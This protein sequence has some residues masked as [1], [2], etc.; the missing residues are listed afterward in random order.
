MMRGFH[1]GNGATGDGKGNVLVCSQGYGRGT[2]AG[3][4]HLNP[5]TCES[6]PLITTQP[7]SSEGRTFNSPNDVCATRDL[8]FV[9]MSDPSYAFKQGFREGK[10]DAPDAI[11][12]ID[13]HEQRA[14]PVDTSLVKPNGV[15]LSPDEATLY[16]TDTGYFDGS[17]ID[18]SQPRCL[19]E[20][21]V[22]SHASGELSHC[23]LFAHVSDGIPDGLKCDAEGN[24]YAG[25]GSGVY[26]W[27][28]DGTYIGAFT[29]DG[30]VANFVFAGPRNNLLIMLNETRIVAC[31]LGVRGDLTNGIDTT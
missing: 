24:V 27:G 23:K 30:G 4:Y 5:W 10:P 16:A 26:V 19:H 2:T 22:S 3:L 15:Q 13:L 21:S 29:V 6:T 28:P 31:E 9:Y 11:W 18:P 7:C 14:R 25:V 8:R 1:A 17:A 20:F 12:R